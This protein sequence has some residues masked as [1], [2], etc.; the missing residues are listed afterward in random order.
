MRLSKALPGTFTAIAG[1][2]AGLLESKES[3]S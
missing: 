2:K 3:L 1:E